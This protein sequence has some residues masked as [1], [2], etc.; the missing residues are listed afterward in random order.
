MNKGHG[1]PTASDYNVLSI[2]TLCFFILFTE[3][4]LIL[5]GDLS[6]L[7]EIKLQQLIFLI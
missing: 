2:L 7:L 3:Y 1:K 4:S 6:S 5:E